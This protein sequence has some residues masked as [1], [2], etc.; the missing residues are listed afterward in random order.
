[1]TTPSPAGTGAIPALTYRPALDG[2]RALAVASVLAFHA[3]SSWAAG[4]YLGVSLFF[5]LSGF[6]ITSLLLTEREATGRIDAGR[7]WSRRFR[8]LL[9]A[10]LTTLALA[11]LYGATIASPDQL[12][13]LRG[14]VLACLAYVANWRFFFANQSYA[15]LFAAPSPV[16]HF[17]SLAIEEQFYLLYPL[18]AIAILAAGRGSRR[19]FAAVLSLLILGS[20]ARALFFGLSE[21]RIYYGTDTRA[22]ELLLGALLAVAVSGRALPRT[23]GR[24]VPWGGLVALG[25]VMWA[26]ATVEQG[27]D[28]LYRGGFVGFAILSCLVVLAASQDRGPVVT[29][30]GVAPL[31]WL[32]QISY[33]VYLYHWLVFQWLTPRRTGL[34]GI[35]LFGLRVGLTLTMAWA[36]YVLL[37]QPIRRARLVRGHAPFVATPVAVLAVTAL[38]LVVTVSPPPPLIDFAAAEEALDVAPLDPRADDVVVDADDD[39]PVPPPPRVAVFGDSTALMTATGLAAWMDRTDLA[40]AGGGNAWFGC[41]ISRGGERRTVPGDEAQVP[42]DCDHWETTWAEAVDDGQPDLALV[43]VG[44]WEVT[45]RLLDGDDTWRAPGDPVYDEYLRSEML[46]ATDVLSADGAEVV[47]LLSP[48]VGPGASGEEID[49][50]GEAGDPSRME[51]FNQLVGEVVASRPGVAHALD[52]AG[53]VADSDDD[54]RLRPDGVHFSSSTATEVATEWLGPELL[55]LHRDAWIDAWVAEHGPPLPEPLRILVVGDSTAMML[56]FGLDG[57]A[58]ATGQAQ[59][60]SLAEI[61][62]GIGR[63]GARDYQGVVTDVPEECA[64]LWDDWRTALDTFDPH[65]VIALTGPFDVTDRRLEDRGE[66]W[67]APG[68]PVYDEFLRD[69]LHDA[70]ALLSASGALVVW[71]TSPLIDLGRADDPPPEEPYPASDPARMERLNELLAE[72]VEDAPR[73]AMADYAGHL[74]TYPGG[75]LDPTLRPDGVHLANAQTR[76]VGDW[77]GPEVLTLFGARAIEDWRAAVDPAT[78]ETVSGATTTTRP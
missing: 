73:A 2:V 35:T 3:G 27:T 67:R 41:S 59:I 70:T 15:D 65:V 78:A 9:P 23:L 52:L 68:D 33:G 58:R 63:G 28:A 50:R 66:A 13:E 5:T 48:P 1:M 42:E 36:S 17:W 75:E 19:V 56:G 49:L 8:R 40:V 72:V 77:L 74:R 24:V 10:A 45:D 53:F 20:L 12:R 64:S 34:D 51:R 16:L 57:W 32:G 29:L 26:V 30:L 46:E 71:L 47:W 43:Q 4:G 60:A 76:R 18:V 6:L 61:G 31:V 37:E 14:D 25:G 55:R 11:C 54:A 39:L 7:F 21:D 62:C 22:A 44:P 69:E 38:L